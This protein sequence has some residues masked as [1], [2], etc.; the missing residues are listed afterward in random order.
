MYIIKVNQKSEEFYISILLNR[1]TGR[2]IFM[3]SP[4]G[5]MSIEEVAEKTPELIF[6]E[7]ID[8]G[9][10]LQPFQTR[11]IAFNLG[12]SGTAF[13]NMQKFLTGIYETF[14]CMR[15]TAS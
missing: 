7:E 10:G 13:K 9:I 6:T 11:N 14:I 2:Y 15:C 3:Y 8:P 12:L 5:G 1:N 4:E